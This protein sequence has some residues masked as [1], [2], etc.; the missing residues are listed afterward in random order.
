MKYS[1]LAVFDHAEYEDMMIGLSR[2]ILEDFPEPEKYHI[3]DLDQFKMTYAALWQDMDRSERLTVDLDILP[4]YEAGDFRLPHDQMVIGLETE[5]DGYEGASVVRAIYYHRAPA[6]S[7]WVGKHKPSTF[8]PSGHVHIFVPLCW[9]GSKGLWTTTGY[10]I[11]WQGDTDTDEGGE[12]CPHI[13][14]RA[15]P[16]HND[17]VFGDETGESERVSHWLLRQMRRVST[18]LECSYLETEVIHPSRLKKM[19]AKK[20]GVFLN[21][22]TRIKLPHHKQVAST[23]MGGHHASPRL[24]RRAGHYRTYHKGER[25]Q[26]RIWIAPTMVG[27]PSR[28]RIKHE[29][30][31]RKPPTKP[32]QPTQEH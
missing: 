5:G 13:E 24:H 22:Y 25:Y 23:G 28:G 4:D 9:G 3:H 21:S 15:F 11:A 8:E 20:K 29:Y 12:R 31:V 30:Q 6:D 19:M 2:W 10:L 16:G 32:T 27:D 14:V 7:F 1:P 18:L 26:R 17:D